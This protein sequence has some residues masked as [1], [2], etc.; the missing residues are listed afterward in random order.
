MEPE[1][2]RPASRW[3]RFWIAVGDWARL[4]WQVLSAILTYLWRLV[5][6]SIRSVWRSFIDFPSWTLLGVL[7]NVFI[8][9]VALWVLLVVGLWLIVRHP[10]TMVAR[11]V[12]DTTIYYLDQGWGSAATSERRQLY[13]YTP[14]GTSISGIRYSWFVELEQA[15]S[16]EKFIEPQHMRA[17]GFFVDP[18][19]TDMNPDQLPVGFA[20]HYDDRLREDVLDIS[21]AA[22]HTGELHTSYKGRPVAIRI[23]GGQAM[24]AF[25][26]TEPAGQFGPSLLAAM[27]ATYLQPFKFS[28]FAERVLG[29]YNTSSAR[30]A[31]HAELG[32]VFWTI[33]KQTVHDKTHN[34]YPIEE[35]F[36]RTDAIARISNKVFADQLDVANDRQG[37]APVSYPPVWDI[38]KYDWVQYTAS[39]AQSL[40][41]NIGESFGV[42][43][44]LPMMDAYGRPL[45]PDQRFVSQTLIDNLKLIEDNLQLLKPPPW[46]E[47]LLGRIDREK[48]ARGRK[49]YEE[50]CAHCHQPCEIDDE[51]RAVAVP[52]RK[53]GEPFWR[54][55]AIPVQ[56]VGTDPNAALNFVNVRVSLEK[57]GITDQQA[58]EVVRELLQ[59]NIKRQNAYRK[60]HN[61]PPLANAE[62]SIEQQVQAINVKSVTI[63]AGLNLLG[64][65]VQKQFFERHGFTEQ[66]KLEYYGSGALDLPRVELIYKARPLAGV[67]ATGPYLHNGSVPTL[68]QMLLPANQRA[69]KFFI[70][71]MNFDPIQVGLSREASSDKGFWFDTSIDGNRNIGHEF[72]AGYSPY[73]AGA[74]AQY[75]V[76]GPELKDNERWDLIE[77]LKIHSDD[78]AP[79]CQAEPPPPPP[80]A[81][82]DSKSG[83]AK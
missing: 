67:W 78:P 13:Y 65:L 70:S 47:E 18:S 10:G 72:R 53:K 76:I 17:L 33:L 3:T 26:A 8:G 39:V 15:D 52:L 1:D 16:R 22:C 31:L 28:R 50:H 6:D 45:P 34:L 83:G 54:T 25:T 66:Q 71:R 36:G 60:A 62:C 74:P 59:E 2:Y 30:D 11:H 40:S 73:R 14:Q 77:Y 20:R 55:T 58:R 61:Q 68:Y 4:L 63:G 46:P 7:R 19:R 81:C 42:G 27:F 37:N 35:G 43:A 32:G 49:L 57:T 23:D 21:C 29:S 48:A 41:R 69:K 75:G 9:A 12:P 79:A 38:W 64:Q 5:S 24:H 82:I 56:E 44:D 51:G 80:V